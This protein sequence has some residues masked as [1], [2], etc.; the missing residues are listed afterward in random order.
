M[1]SIY[2][3]QVVGRKTFLNTIVLSPSRLPVSPGI[4]NSLAVSLRGIVSISIY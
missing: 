4:T 3:G 1:Q 2:V